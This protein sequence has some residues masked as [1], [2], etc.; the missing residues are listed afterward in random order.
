MNASFRLRW[1]ADWGSLFALCTLLLW[2]AWISMDWP[3]T[4]VDLYGTV[5]FYGWIR[6]SVEQMFDPSFTQLFF[7]PNGKD[8]FAHTGNNFIDA[9][10]SIPFQWMFGRW[11]PATFMTALLLGN[12]IGLRW[13]LRE[14]GCTW[15]LRWIFGVLWLL[16]PYCIAELSMG[17]PT[18]LLLFPTFCAL[19]FV[20]RMV[21]EGEEEQRS[22]VGLGL[23][24]ALQGW[25]YWF[26]GFFVVQLLILYGVTLVWR[27]QINWTTFRVPLIQSVALCLLLISPAVIL[28]STVVS[29][30]EIPGMGVLKGVSLQD[31]RSSMVPWIRGFQLFEPIGHPIFQNTLWG[32]ALLCS[33]VGMYKYRSWMFVALGMT[34][35]ALGPFQSLGEQ[36]IL[37]YPYLWMVSALPFFERLWFPYR[38]LGFVFVALITHLALFTRTWQLN[39]Q[40]RIL[41]PLIILSMGAW[42]LH[43]VESLPLV[44]TEMPKS[45]VK[46]CMDAPTIQIPIGFVHPTMTWQ[47]HNPQP[48]FGGMGENGLLFLPDGYN[49][50]LQNPFVQYLKSASLIVHTKRTYSPFDKER[51]VDIGFRYVL[52]DRSMTEMERFKRQNLEGE[53]PTDVFKIQQNL[54]DTLGNPV[55]VDAQWLLFDLDGSDVSNEVFPHLFDWSWGQPSISAYEERLR[56]LGRVPN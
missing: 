51:I 41:M 52:W 10:L 27:K 3:G 12:V 5:W 49:A 45:S 4:G 54:I 19:V 47:T 9:Y 32:S 25:C 13:W 30:Q 44:H 48:Y 55:C 53:R 37:N 56:E 23:S 29:Q 24:V 21:E 20:K 38:A 2:P 6:Q 8:I 39:I 31:V 15:Y 1:C 33:M 42:D 22:W 26:Y 50:R 34:I 40:T 46:E 18:Q 14:L 35:V 7:Y 43:Y 28:M 36:E 11:F 16:N 17:R